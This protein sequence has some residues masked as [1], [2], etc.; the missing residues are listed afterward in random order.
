MVANVEP[1]FYQIQK[2]E[3]VVRKGDRVSPRAAAQT[4]DPVKSAADPVR[5]GVVLGAF[6]SSLILSIGFFVAPSGKPG[7]PLRCKD[8][9]LALAGAVPV[10]RGG[11][12]GRSALPP[13]FDSLTLMAG[14][15]AW[16][17]PIA[18]GVGLVAMVFAAR[19]Y[20]TMSL[21]LCFFAMLMFQ[22]DYTFFL[23]HFLGGML[24]TWLVTN[25]QTRQD[26]VWS[27]IPLTVGQS[28][29]WLGMA[30]LARISPNELPMPT[31][32]RGHRRPCRP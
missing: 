3:L 12:G 29:I 32:G 22:A 28:L 20:C 27:I 5:W 13:V 24:A 1:V 16:A 7:T 23:Y 9:L 6:L 2:G 21:L 11:R 31:G 14:Y 10:Q 15:A 25:A 18:G 8:M 4:A 19:R 26:V 30:L 17:V